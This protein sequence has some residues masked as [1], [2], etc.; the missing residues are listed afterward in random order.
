M[1]HCLICVSVNHANHNTSK[2]VDKHC[3][4]YA[5]QRG[6]GGGGGA[7]ETF[8]LG[9]ALKGKTCSRGERNLSLK[10]SLFCYKK[11]A[12]IVTH[13]KGRLLKQAVIIIDCDHIQLG[14]SLKGKNLL[15]EGANSFL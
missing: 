6:G 5:H 10:S 14:T 15:P 8:K 1:H 3:N 11:Q 12:V 4:S 9:T 2:G 7:T 13:I